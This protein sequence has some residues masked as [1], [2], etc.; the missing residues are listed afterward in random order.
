MRKAKRKI[1]Q[2]LIIAAALQLIK[3]KGSSN[4]LTVR[5]IAHSLQCSHPNIYN[6]YSSMDQIRWACLLKVLQI[7]I[8]TVLHKLPDELSGDELM[9]FFFAEL[10][11][12]YLQNRGWYNLIWFDQISGEIP[13][14]V[15]QMIVQPRQKFCEILQAAYPHQDLSEWTEP[16][17]DIVHNYIHGQIARYLMGRAIHHP[18]QQIKQKITSTCLEIIRLYLA[19]KI[20]TSRRESL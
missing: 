3:Q 5:D 11:D 4:W 17:A 2:E 18:P 8:D 16:I 1:D 19:D 15:Q 6:Y 13:A 20:E 12:F 14:A 7:E 10:V 9:Q